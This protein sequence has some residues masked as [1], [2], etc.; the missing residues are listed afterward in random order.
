MVQNVQS[1]EQ[2]REQNQNHFRL[3]GIFIRC[4]INYFVLPGPNT[5]R[6]NTNN[7][8]Q[9]ELNQRTKTIFGMETVF[10]IVNYN[11]CLENRK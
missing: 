10:C 8:Q 9:H 7:Q 1:N 11:V 4:L 3:N 6:I 5:E 2:P